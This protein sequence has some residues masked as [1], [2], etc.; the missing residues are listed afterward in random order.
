[1]EARRL[2]VGSYLKSA[3]KRMEEID[4]SER[5]LI[6]PGTQF[7]NWWDI[8]MIVALV[9]TTIVTPYEVALTS[10][11][12]LNWLFALNRIVDSIFWV[13]MYV[14]FHMIFQTDSGATMTNRSA[15]RQRYLRGWFG[16]DFITTL[17]FDCLGFLEVGNEDI[18]K[19]RLVR[20]LRLLRLLRIL[21]ASRVLQR[22]EFKLGIIS[23]TLKTYKVGFGLLVGTHWLA[24]AIALF[25]SIEAPT[26]YTWVSAWIDGEYNVPPQCV[27][28]ADDGADG[29]NVIINGA[30]RNTYSG[31]CYPMRN[32]Y[33]ASLHFAIMTV[34][35]IGYGDMVPK[36]HNERIF[37]VAWQLT[38]AMLW[39]CVVAEV[40]AVATAGDPVDVAYNHSVDDLNMYMSKHAVEQSE[41]FAVRRY[42]AFA[43]HGMREKSYKATLADLPPVLAQ[44]VLQPPRWLQRPCQITFMTAASD[45]FC[46]ALIVKLKCLSMPPQA[47]I[48]T[49]KR[50]YVLRTGCLCADGDL[51]TST[52]K[53]ICWGGNDFFLKGA[54]REFV[55]PV[56]LLAVTYV[57]LHHFGQDELDELLEFFQTEAAAINRRI[58]WAVVFARMRF[59]AKKAEEQDL[60][61]MSPAGVINSLFST[62]Q[63]GLT[64]TVRREAPKSETPAPPA[65]G[66]SEL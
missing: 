23:T 27:T 38:A 8:I 63:A 20:L 51:V 26:T 66:I 24:C 58:N 9:F 19:V 30:V 36:N 59:L 62:P 54:D 48:A 11:V 4:R 57:E 22:W 31:E 45:S 33:S 35:S 61:A 44:K 18:E 42:L 49:G 17:P 29:G 52:A 34:T 2:S 5:G 16:I 55:V 14:N 46:A 3:E 10:N 6:K 25:A 50:C 12:A 56:T 43:K 1:M 13:D 28:T 64:R 32:L 37:G 7:T 53:L 15:I 21:R 65:P 40:V 39:A 47:C 41:R 60:D